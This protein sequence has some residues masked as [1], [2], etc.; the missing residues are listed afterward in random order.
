MFGFGKKKNNNVSVGLKDLNKK[1]IEIHNALQEKVK[2]YLLEDEVVHQ[3]GRLIK[4]SY[5]ATN[6]R[7][8]S[9]LAMSSKLKGVQ[10]DSYYYSN[11]SGIKYS[12]SF[13]KKLNYDSMTIDLKGTIQ[14]VKIQLPSEVTKEMYKTI[15]N[16]ISSNA[17]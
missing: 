8:I 5:F 10:V 13:S 16:Y 6:K 1:E 14:K 9:M 2:E 4:T 17:I 15:S 11:M 7:I 12:E 3:E